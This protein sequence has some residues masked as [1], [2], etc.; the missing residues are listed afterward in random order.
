MC[1]TAVC[2]T[3]GITLSLAYLVDAYRELAGDALASCIIIRNTMSFAIGYGI[4]P[5]LDGLGLQDCFV[6]VAFVGLA[7]CL[8][9]LPMIWWGRRL[10]EAKRLD[11]W[12]EVRVRLERHGA[13]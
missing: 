8:V 13:H 3:A 11:Y 5:W 9:F 7:I 6:S 10:R 1:T 2:N 4:T 12:R